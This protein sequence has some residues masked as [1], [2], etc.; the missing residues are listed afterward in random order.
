MLT[1]SVAY[2][3]VAHVI[4]RN[5]V[6][7]RWTKQQRHALVRKM[8]SPERPPFDINVIPWNDTGFHVGSNVS[9]ISWYRI[10]LQWRH[11]GRYSISNHRRLYC[12]LNYLLRHRWKKTPKL[13]VTGLCEG[14]SPVT[15]TW[16]QWPQWVKKGWRNTAKSR[17]TWCLFLPSALDGEI[18]FCISMDVGTWILLISCARRFKLV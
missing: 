1:I 6:E 3:F 17:G 13:L 15:V 5:I 11:N 10:S 7:A 16:R 2:L 18:Y 12:L 14:N 9:V 4:I 8:M